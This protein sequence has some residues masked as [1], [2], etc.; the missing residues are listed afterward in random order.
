MIFMREEKVVILDKTFPEETD[1]QNLYNTEKTSKPIE[2]KILSED[3]INEDLNRK[4]TISRISLDDLLDEE[5]TI[6]R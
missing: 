2:I 3:E 5:R 6:I 1:E 4:F